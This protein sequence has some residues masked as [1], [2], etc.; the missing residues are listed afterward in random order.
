M[1]GVLAPAPGLMMLTV[2]PVPSISIVS[3]FVVTLTMRPQ[4]CSTMTGAT[5]RAIWS[6]AM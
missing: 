6:A 3:S 5:R 2:S 1:P 4:P